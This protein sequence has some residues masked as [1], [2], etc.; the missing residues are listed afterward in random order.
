MNRLIADNRCF[1]P[2]SIADHS[3]AAITRGTMSIGQA[4]SVPCPSWYT[5]NVMPSARMSTSARR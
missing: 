5:V 2:R 3:D 1:R 4:R